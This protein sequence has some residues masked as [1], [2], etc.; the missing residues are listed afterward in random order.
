MMVESVGGNPTDVA[1]ADSWTGG[2]NPNPFDAIVT[3]PPIDISD[4]ENSCYI[5]FAQLEE[6]ILHRAA[7]NHARMVLILVPEFIDNLPCLTG[8]L[9]LDT[10]I[11]LPSGL[12]PGMRNKGAIHIYKQNRPAGAPVRILLLG[13]IYQNEGDEQPY[14]KVFDLHQYYSLDL[15][16]NNDYCTYIPK[17]E[18]KGYYYSLFPKQDLT[19]L[20][21][22]DTGQKKVKMA[23]LFVEPDALP[24]AHEK[25]ENLVFRR[26]L[27]YDIYQ[28]LLNQNR[29]SPTINFMIHKGPT[30]VQ[31][32]KYLLEQY[33]ARIYGLHTAEDEHF[34][35]QAGI[36]V[37]RINERLVLPEYV[38]YLLM[39][40]YRDAISQFPSI[41]YCMTMPVIIDNFDHQ[42]RIVNEF[43]KVSQSQLEGTL[44]SLG[45][46]QEANHTKSLTRHRIE[47]LLYRLEQLQPGAADYAP[48]LRALRD[49]IEYI[50][51]LEE[52]SRATTLRCYLPE[53]PEDFIRYIRTYAERWGNYGY[54]CFELTIDNRFQEEAPV[55]YD[56]TLMTVLLDAIL[57][58]AVR[59]GFNRERKSGN[60]V[61][62][63]LSKVQ[64]EER[65][66][67]LLQVSN[68]GAPLP[69]GFTLQNYVTCGRYS[70]DAVSSGMG[71]YHVHQVTQGHHGYLYIDHNDQWNLIVEI[72]LPLDTEQTNTLNTYE[73]G[74]SCI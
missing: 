17:S 34:M 61:E 13:S 27:S 29:Y 16:Q 65:P 54:Q 37:F 31:R 25:C 26:Y 3:C 53:W 15:K 4:T 62:I 56:A 58:N 18:L 70:S 51:R 41:R 47:Q 1:C 12:I 59:H 74:E 2:W 23:D 64:H 35:V 68:N 7:R 30:Y 21:K 14:H 66:Y 5:T 72:L 71:G 69:E 9:Q 52:Y 42:R 36:S 73:H 44:K 67:L 22:V 11:E 55:R 60:R 24:P 8:E 45:V 32:G 6:I 46:R 19:T 43:K 38:L 50:E 63:T 49:N 48:T 10:Y 40:Q 28:V 57:D 33:D 39:R 20:P